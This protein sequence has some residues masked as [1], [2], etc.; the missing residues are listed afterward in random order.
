MGILH[1]PFVVVNCV[2]LQYVLGSIPGRNTL[3]SFFPAVGLFDL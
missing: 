1:V 2:K 3:F